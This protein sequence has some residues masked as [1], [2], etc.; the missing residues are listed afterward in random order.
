MGLSRFL[1]PKAV[2]VLIILLFDTFAAGLSPEKRLYCDCNSGEGSCVGNTNTIVAAPVSNSPFVTTYTL[3][4]NASTE[5]TESCPS[6][7]QQVTD[8][9]VRDVDAGYKPSPC[10]K[11]VTCVCSSTVVQD[12]TPCSK[13]EY[14]KW[15]C[16]HTIGG[17]T[18]M[19]IT[20][21]DDAVHLTKIAAGALLRDGTAN[22]EF[23][24]C[25]TA[26]S[27]QPCHGILCVHQHTLVDVPGG[28]KEAMHI[29]KDDYL[30][31][32]KGSPLQVLN[33]VK[34]GFSSEFV[35]IE[36]NAL[37]LG[38]PSNPLMLTDHHHVVINGTEV[39]TRDMLKMNLNCKAVSLDKA[40]PVYNF[41][42]LN[43]SYYTLS[44]LK[45]VSWSRNE[46][47]DMHGKKFDVQ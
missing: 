19:T 34:S 23:L 12:T 31:D 44:G 11:N 40:V 45:T 10:D 25:F 9:I 43:R 21:G 22:Q 8:L 30:L 28:V 20:K 14:N 35:L 18:T 6:S 37:G 46:F 32:E 41:I 36:K 38:E 47:D 3:C 13:Y 33:T 42:T 1:F 15:Q 26:L 27:C 5:S 29:Y 24:A 16:K 2:L 4:K 17:C 7:T 39:L